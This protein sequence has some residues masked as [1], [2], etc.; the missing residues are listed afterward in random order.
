[1]NV[2][3]KEY[4]SLVGPRMKEGYNNP[5]WLIKKD[6]ILA[7]DN[8]KCQICDSGKYLKVHHTYYDDKKPV[9]DYPDKSLITLCRICHKRAH[10]IK[11]TINDLSG[12]YHISLLK[13]IYLAENDEELNTE[14]PQEVKYILTGNDKNKITK[15]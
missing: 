7:R 8:Y 10:D 14:K 5:K 3:F 6:K 12:K 4:E 11:E 2:P 9:W 15:K 13:E 1:M